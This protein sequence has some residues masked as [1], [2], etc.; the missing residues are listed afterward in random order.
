MKDGWNLSR[1]RPP[2]VAES[3]SAHPSL[4]LLARVCIYMHTYAHTTTVSIVLM[5]T[6][7]R[8]MHSM[9]MRTYMHTSS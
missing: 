7:T 9:H 5:H 1:V 6:T 8:R 2:I 3:L 4:Y